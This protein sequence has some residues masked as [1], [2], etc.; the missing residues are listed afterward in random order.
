MKP[1]D[2]ILSVTVCGGLFGEAR[3]DTMKVVPRKIVGLVSL[4]IL[5]VMFSVAVSRGM[6]EAINTEI[7]RYQGINTN[8]LYFF[9]L[10]IVFGY[11]VGWARSKFKIAA[12]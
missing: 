8:Y 11:F 3:K 6:L 2:I 1:A 12:H 4:I 10:V 9:F 5:P 7:S